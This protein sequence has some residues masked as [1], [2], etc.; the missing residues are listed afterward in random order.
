MRYLKWSNSQRKQNGDYQKIWGG[1]VVFFMGIRVSVLQDEK[2]Q[3]IYFTTMEMNLT[4]LND[5][6]KNS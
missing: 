5:T 4:L 6:V 2:V 1:S 3:E